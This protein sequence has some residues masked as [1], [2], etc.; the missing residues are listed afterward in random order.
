[1]GFLLPRAGAWSIAGLCGWRFDGRRKRALC[2][3][4]AARA[5]GA[6]FPRLPAAGGHAQ[7]LAAR[8]APTCGMGM[9]S[10]TGRECG[11]GPRCRVAVAGQ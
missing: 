2:P 11:R 9:S 7:L 3:A 1:M 8:V 4:Q 5:L 10:H 6:M